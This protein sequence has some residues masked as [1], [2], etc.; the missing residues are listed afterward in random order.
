M[1]PPNH[2]KLR[3]I[4]IPSRNKTKLKKSSKNKKIKK[5]K[6]MLVI[7]LGLSNINLYIV[8][9]NNNNNNNNKVINLKRKEVKLKKK[10]IY[11]LLFLMLLPLVSAIPYFS[12]VQQSP[13]D[14]SNTNLFT[15]IL[16]ITYNIT[17]TIGLN[18]STVNIYYK[19]N[20]SYSECEIYINGTASCDYQQRS[21][22]SSSS[23]LYS[24]N[25]NGRDVYPGTYNY[26]E[27]I[28]IN[29]AHQSYLLN[30]NSSYLKIRLFNVTNKKSYG[31]FELFA[32]ASSTSGPLRIY[33]CNS[34]Y[35]YGIPLT[36]PNCID[37]YN[38][39][40][41]V[42]FNHSHSQNSYHQL[43]PFAV[44]TTN[45][46]INNDIYV[47]PTSYF[48]LRGRDDSDWKAYYI[49]QISRTD[50]IQNLSAG[51]TTTLR[52]NAVGSTTNLQSTCTPT[53]TANWQAV[54]DI[55]SDGD[56]TRLHSPS[57]TVITYDL[58]NVPDL[59]VVPTTIKKVTVYMVVRATTQCGSLCQARTELRTNGV[60]HHGT[61]ITLSGTTYTTYS[62]EYVNNPQT[63]QP[64]TISEINALQIGVGLKSRTDSNNWRARATQVYA[65]VEYT[66][67]NNFIGTVDAHLH[68]YDNDAFHYYVCAKDTSNNNNCS[69]TRSDLL[70]LAGLP[71]LAPEVTAPV[72]GYYSGDITLNYTESISPNEYPIIFYNISLVYPNTTFIQTIKSNNTINLSYVWNSIEAGDGSYR[73]EVKACDNQNQCSSGRSQ[74]FT[75]DNT[76]PIIS[77][78]SPTEISGSTLNNR[79]NIQVNVTST[80]SYFDRIRIL[81]Y[82]SSQEIIQVVSLFSSPAFWNFTNLA[83]GTYYFN[84]TALDLANNLNSTETRNITI[85]TSGPNVQ[86]VSPTTPEGEYLQ[87]WIYVNVTA[88]DIPSGLKNIT[89]YLYNS[90]NNLINS[91]TNT[92]SPLQI[93]FTNLAY[94]TYYLN[95]TAYDNLNNLN[96]TETRIIV[97]SL[98]PDT[99]PP[100]TITDLSS[101]VINYTSINWQWTNP[102]DEDF[103]YAILYLNGVNIINTT[104][105]YYNATELTCN[106]A[107]NLTIYTKDHAGNINTTYCCVA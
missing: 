26:N 43:I 90:S 14:I 52:P 102:V 50:T 70:N 32:N 98:T 46:K 105:N 64:W 18:T 93:N 37:F 11:G 89:I 48:I 44:N 51:I 74:I 76:R 65:I 68:Q 81:L 67:W 9:N 73:I 80:D 31:I 103:Y 72:A 95:A 27:T 30:S 15:S 36:S 99:T 6:E 24:F 61:T 21:F 82:N 59:A 86:F 10:F 60:D 29:T 54:D 79:S 91:T 92:T 62:T 35:A 104:Y 19:T 71:P 2:S 40:S 55:T 101:N 42:A 38:L 49:P 25:L 75:I 33:Y 107:Y 96:S 84:A 94:D 87:D 83:D 39:E 7:A 1:K 97:L 3:G 47:T 17:D 58:Y 106:T 4:P 34:S 23:N 78:V 5:N 12:F 66:N 100:A 85:D 57:T 22:S 56:I 8:N 88:A 63:G 41:N 45:G 69:E 77:F 13:A 53:C 16:N 28:M 20:S